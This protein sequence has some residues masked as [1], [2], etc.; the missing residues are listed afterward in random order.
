MNNNGYVLITGAGSG[1][2]KSFAIEFAKRNFPVVLVGR[3]KSKLDTVS[4]ECGNNNSLVIVADV[5]KHDEVERCFKEA[6]DWKGFPSIVISCAGEGVFGQVGTFKDD[7]IERVLSGNL[8]GTI[9]VSQKGFIEMK[10]K[11]G[12]IVNV[13]STAATI[14]RVNESVYCAAKWGAKGFTESL[15]LETKGTKVKV[16]GVYPGG[17]QTPFWSEKSGMQPDTSG[18]MKSDELAKTLADNILD[19]QSLYVADI[20]LNRI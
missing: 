10:E 4:S 14:G 13:M 15:R 5:S 17:I 7:H 12:T 20:I 18:F 3:T 1:L 2:G 19:K 6:N 16:I 9:F 11:G 8:V